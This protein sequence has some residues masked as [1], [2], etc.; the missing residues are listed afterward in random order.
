MIQSK[1]LKISQCRKIDGTLCSFVVNEQRLILLCIKPQDYP[2]AGLGMLCWAM[3]F[4]RGRVVQGLLCWVNFL[5][6]KTRMKNFIALLTFTLLHP[7][8][9][10]LT[11][12]SSLS[13]YDS[14][15]YPQVHYMAATL[16][17]CEY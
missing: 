13:C 12:L 3:Y 14:A 8:L 16:L 10:E 2:T 15:Y 6:K 7:A 5:A 1:M 17:F 4:G 11:R 9:K